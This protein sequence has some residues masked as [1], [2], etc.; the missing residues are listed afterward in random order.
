MG[1]GSIEGE[2]NADVGIADTDKAIWVR[3]AKS[4]CGKGVPTDR[5]I[6][7]ANGRAGAKWK[8]ICIISS[9]KK[10]KI[11]E[12]IEEARSLGRKKAKESGK[13][14]KLKIKI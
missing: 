8:E 2:L 3:A 12:T 11:I 1:S 5:G 9:T 13:I 7:R 10:N 4:D 6:S 14:L